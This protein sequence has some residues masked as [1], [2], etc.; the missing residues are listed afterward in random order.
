[1]EPSLGL[2]DMLVWCTIILPAIL[3]ILCY[4]YR[5]LARYYIYMHALHV[6]LTRMLPNP[7]G[8]YVSI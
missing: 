7:E 4:K 8:E 5:F 1:M 2:I 3:D 6:T